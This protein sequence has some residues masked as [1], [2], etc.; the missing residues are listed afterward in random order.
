MQQIFLLLLKI[1]FIA[2][3][4]SEIFRLK[5]INARKFN[6]RIFHNLEK[7]NPLCL[8]FYH[9][10]VFYSITLIIFLY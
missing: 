9:I 3:I 4:D 8:F 2:L 5:N 7:K 1:F 6:E 10:E